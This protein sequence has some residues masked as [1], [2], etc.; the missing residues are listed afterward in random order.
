MCWLLSSSGSGC[1]SGEDD[2]VG[3]L[4]VGFSVVV[5]LDAVEGGVT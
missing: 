2:V 1:G 3:M 4:F 5:V